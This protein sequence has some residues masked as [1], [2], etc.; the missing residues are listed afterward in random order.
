M[1]DRP[2]QTRWKASFYRAESQLCLAVGFQTDWL[3][4]V[5]RGGLWHGPYTMSLVQ[6]CASAL[7]LTSAMTM[8]PTCPM[9]LALPSAMILTLSSDETLVHTDDSGADLRQL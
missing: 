6:T 8:A 5:R 7:A 3:G 1:V 2:H 9:T 4:L